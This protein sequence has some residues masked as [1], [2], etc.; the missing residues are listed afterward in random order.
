MVL[1]LN[2]IVWSLDDALPQRSDEPTNHPM[3]E[4]AADNGNS[5][6]VSSEK[7]HIDFTAEFF[8]INIARVRF[9]YVLDDEFLLVN[10]YGA[11]GRNGMRSAFEQY[12]GKV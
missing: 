2:V 9:H 6:I 5:T 10:I 3:T 8:C 1:W 11:V 12:V 7:N 4:A